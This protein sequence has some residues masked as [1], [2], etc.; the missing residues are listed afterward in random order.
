MRTT[1]CSAPSPPFE[2]LGNLSGRERI[3]RNRGCNPSGERIDWNGGKSKRTKGKDGY[4]D[5]T[6]QHVSVSQGTELFTLRDYPR[7]CR[8]ATTKVTLV[9]IIFGLWPLYCGGWSNCI[10]KEL[11]SLN[12][13]SYFSLS[14]LL[15]EIAS[16][17]SECFSDGCAAQETAQGLIGD[18]SLLTRVLYRGIVKN[19]H[20]HLTV[21]AL[22]I[23]T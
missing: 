6:I 11:I 19:H 5:N 4:F 12:L 7:S 23:S 21:F 18:F 9:R 17:R 22:G 2:S 15:A 1:S 16:M 3:D 8:D 14:E 13:N 20:W 10:H